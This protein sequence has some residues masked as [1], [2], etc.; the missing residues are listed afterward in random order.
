MSR[1][2]F[3]LGALVSTPG[4]LEAL[5]RNRIGPAAYLARHQQGDWGDLGTGDKRAND[6][7]L[8]AGAR[9]LSAY[10]LADKT[11]IW[12]ITEADRSSTC[13]LLPEEY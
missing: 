11:K 4:A 8:K 1:V 5:E 6:H 9:L 12:V 7:A 13:V 3:P 2:S 10:V